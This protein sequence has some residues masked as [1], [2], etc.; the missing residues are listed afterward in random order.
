MVM[1]YILAFA[2]FV[3]INGL[4]V[5]QEGN[6][7]S[8]CI[9]HG[10]RAVSALGGY[11]MVVLGD[12]DIVSKS[13]AYQGFWDIRS[14]EELA[15]QAGTTLPPPGTMLDIGANIG[16][17][18]FLF[19]SKGYHVIAV[20]PMTRNRAAIEATLCLNPQ[21]R[22]FV[23]IVPAALV[24]PQEVGHNTCVVKSTNAAVNIGNGYLTCGTG[25]EAC[26]QG[27]LNCENVPSKTLD[28]VLVEVGATS[29]DVVKMDVEN[30]ECQVFSGGQTLFTK[31]HPKIL[32]VETMWGNTAKCVQDEAAKHGYYTSPGG[33]N[34]TMT[35]HAHV[36]FL[37]H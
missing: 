8:G 28:A 34:T 14:A 36:S 6:S 3:G 21:F 37:H 30:Y 1:H 35:S 18:V 32:Q 17:F 31:F 11:Q 20:E 13:I 27:D 33:E 15:Q 29:V 7:S 19:A 26:A 9:P 25:V 10:M 2:C 16:Y 5:R 23:R 4:V 22:Q 24:S 12:D